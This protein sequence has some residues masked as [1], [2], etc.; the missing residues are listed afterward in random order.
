MPPRIRRLMQAA[1]AVLAVAAY[2]LPI[3]MGVITYAAHDLYHLREGLG[4]V[5]THVASADT[6]PPGFVHEHGSG[7]H[8][9]DAATDA[10]LSAA[11]HEESSESEH[12]MASMDLVGHLPGQAETVVLAPALLST[13]PHSLVKG[14]LLLP[15]APPL[16]PPRV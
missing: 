2:A 15:S 6:P 9:H 8:S 12:T 7:M 13:V 14:H 3:G 10:L 11:Q 5:A 4:R 1:A 16:P